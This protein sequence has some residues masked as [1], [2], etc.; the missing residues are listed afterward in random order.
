MKSFK[1]FLLSEES[2]AFENSNG[3]QRHNMPQI[4]KVHHPKFIDFLLNDG[5]DVTYMQVAVTSLKPTQSEYN[6]TKVKLF[7]TFDLEVLS[8]NVIISSDGYVLDG[9][10][11]Y[12]ALLDAYPDEFMNVIKVDL[13]INSLIA[14]CFEFPETTIE[15]V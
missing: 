8:S 9:H 13:K 4:K 11:R 1:D 10:H 15:A 7:T 12:K 2:Q 14:K 6:P 3:V 5:I